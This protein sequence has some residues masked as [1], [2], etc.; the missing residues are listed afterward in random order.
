M[1]APSERKGCLCESGWSQLC[2]SEVILEQI[3]EVLGF[4]SLFG[5]FFGTMFPLLAW[6]SIPGKSFS[7]PCLITL[8]GSQI[9]ACLADGCTTSTSS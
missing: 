5:D 2:L 7:S 8:G 3:A 4:I 6:C 1:L 9:S